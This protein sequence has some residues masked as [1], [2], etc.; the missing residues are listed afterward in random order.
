MREIKFKKQ[1]IKFFPRDDSDS[2]VIDEIFVNKMYRSLEGLISSLIN[3]ILDIGA[4]IGCFSVYARLSNP[5][6][7]II[8]LEP[9]PSNFKLLKENLKLNHFK[10]IICKNQAL[11]SGDD[12]TVKLFLNRDSHNHS[13]FYK[14]KNSI[15]VPATTL[16]EIIK[17]N[18]LT[19]IGLLKMDIEGEEFDIVRNIEQNTWNKIRNIAVEYHEFNGNKRSDLENILRTRGFSAEHFPNH[20]DKRFGLLVCR[21]KK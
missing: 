2:S 9:E 15:K 19:K 14:T 1:S 5:Q 10:N 18:K 3:P 8:A 16:E 12:K 21:N 20:F 7:K 13:T 4:H 11:I 6:S 17:K